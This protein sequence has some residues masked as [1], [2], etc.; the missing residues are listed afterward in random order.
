M[1][2]RFAAWLIVPGLLA[3][4]VLAGP[5]LGAPG[6]NGPTTPYRALYTGA[7]T[8]GTVATDTAA[9]TLGVRFTPTV[10]GYLDSVE[11]YRGSSANTARHVS[12]WAA[13]GT[14]LATASTPDTRLGWNWGRFDRPVRVTA[15]TMYVA[16]YH[17]PAGRY[18]SDSNGFASSRAVGP[19]TVSAGDGVYRYGSVAAFPDQRWRSS[20]YF[21]SPVFTADLAGASASPARTPTATAT[22]SPTTTSASPTPTSTPTSDPT[23]NP[24]GEPCRLPGDG[25]C[26]PYSYSKISMSN[27]YNTY[28]NNQLWGCGAPG[29]CGP[30]TMKA[31]GAGR[32]EVTS[33]QRAGNTGVLTY[34]NTQQLLNT[35]N[36]RGWNGPGPHT[37]TPV[38]SLA[39]LESSYS[40]RMNENDGTIAQAAYDIWTS[41][42]EIMIWVD[43]TDLRGSGG[44]ERVDSGT[45][46][47]QPFT[48]YVYGGSL[49]I[50][51]FDRNRRSATVDILEA[52]NWLVQKG[53][54]P[55]STTIGQ[56][57]FGF[58]ICSTGGVAETFEVLDY[59]LTAVPK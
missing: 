32:W 25:A 38:S 1:R 36:G 35:W 44:A 31:W 55:A 29:S 27:G 15:G 57:N 18:N 47:G 7:S 13:T 49:P 6:S 59:S 5:V 50:I 22:P 45:I 40:E 28:A 33:T 3:G 12:L 56:V 24:T 46:D 17:A 21:V 9:V 34:P 2:G 51:K 53:H 41:A 20:S 4:A 14:R 52:L 16:A 11:F 10:D 43:T 39:K 42:G 58:E 8:T 23:S 19:L 30:Q 26:G 54:I 48:Y 37:D